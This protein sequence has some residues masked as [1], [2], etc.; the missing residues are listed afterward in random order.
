MDTLKNKNKLIAYI[1]IGL[2]VYFLIKQ[3]DL[4]LFKPFIGWP[5]VIAVIGI[6]FLLHSYTA[7]LHDNLFIGVILLGLGI[8]FHGLKTSPAWY[9]HWSIYTLI[10]GVAYGIL[11]FKTKRG[12]IPAI[13]LLSLSSIMIFSITLPEWFQPVYIVIDFIDTFWPVILL[14][15]GVYFL[16]KK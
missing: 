16:W 4:P 13:V 11:F 5:T 1:L 10:I 8:H 7:S 14:G 3:L 9:D 2:G 15:I 12:L 6:A